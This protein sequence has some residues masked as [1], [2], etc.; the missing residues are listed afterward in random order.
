[1]SA[2]ARNSTGTDARKQG[3]AGA[4]HLTAPAAASVSAGAC[5]NVVEEAFWLEFAANVM[6]QLVWPALRAGEITKAPKAHL[7][8]PTWWTDGIVPILEDERVYK[9]HW[10]GSKK[11]A[12]RC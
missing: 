7:D 12:K 2:A 4:A 3:E 11:K 6:E 8:N 5:R 9:L 1:M 10:K